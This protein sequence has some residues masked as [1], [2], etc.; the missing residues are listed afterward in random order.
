MALFGD[1]DQDGN[2]NNFIMVEDR[3]TFA[4]NDDGHPA[5]ET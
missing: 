2:G 4:G 3:E 5:Y 1:T